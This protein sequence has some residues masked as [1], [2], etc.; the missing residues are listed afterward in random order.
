MIRLA[1][2]EHVRPLRTRLLRPDGP[3]GRLLTFDADGWTDDRAVHVAAEQDGAV[4]GVATIYLH[5]PPAGVFASVPAGMAWQLRGMATAEAVRGTGVGADVLAACLTAVADRGGAFVWCNART[6]AA[7]FYA[8]L[9]WTQAG[10]AFDV[11]GV[12][13]HV[14]MGREVGPVGYAGPS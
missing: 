8:R 10:D 1:P 2:A 3:A 6:T 7:G 13:P 9:G 14:R 11:P 5:D 4:V 12:G